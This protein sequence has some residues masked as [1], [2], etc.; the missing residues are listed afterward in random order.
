MTASE[1]FSKSVLVSCPSFFMS[2][3]WGH[4]YRRL[5]NASETCPCCVSF[6]KL[7][8]VRWI[9]VTTLLWRGWGGGLYFPRQD[10]YR[11]CHV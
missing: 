5:F 4:F 6:Q 1:L 9:H 11:A 8:E 10:N 2:S 3:G 7:I